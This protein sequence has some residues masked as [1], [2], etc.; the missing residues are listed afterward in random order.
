MSPGWAQ[1][2]MGNTLVECT[3]HAPVQTLVYRRQRSF[4]P[5]RLWAVL[6]SST[7]RNVF[8]TMGHFWIASNPDLVLMLSTKG[9][10]VDIWVAGEWV[11][12]RRTQ[13]QLQYAQSNLSLYPTPSLNKFGSPLPSPLGAP[14]AEGK[15]FAFGSMSNLLRARA[16]AHA[17]SLSRSGYSTPDEVCYLVCS[18]CFGITEHRFTGSFTF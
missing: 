11:A 15:V 8:R 10:K 4:H 6:Q 12:S 17:A 1:Q 3:E 18:A 13:Q 2:L 7:L 16:A 5:A 14:S 9:P